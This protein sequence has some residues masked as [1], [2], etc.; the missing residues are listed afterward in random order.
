MKK[1][2]NWVIILLMLQFLVV[3]N[4]CLNSENSNRVTMN[5][6]EFWNN[7]TFSEDN[8]TLIYR[9]MLESLD[10]GDILII[11]DIINNIS[12]RSIENYSL[13]ECK[14]LLGQPSPFPIEG[15]ITNEFM[16]GDRIMLTLTII[17]VNTTR[18]MYGQTWIWEMETIQERWDSLNNSIVPIPRHYIHRIT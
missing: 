15:D 5:A 1:I 17:N 6:W 12:Y 2:M 13:I 8:E 16:I 18:Q 10:T 4:G 3:M 7:H 14:S 9:S 11:K